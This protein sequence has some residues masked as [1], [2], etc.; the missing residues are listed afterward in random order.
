MKPKLTKALIVKHAI[1][2]ADQHGLEALSMRGL[3]STLDVKA[4]SLYNHIKNK[5]DL[6]ESMIDQ[7]IGYLSYEHQGIW[8]EAV[9]A[10]SR[11]L[12]E[13]LLKHRWGVLPLMYGF[14]TGPFITKD[15]DRSIGILRQAGFSYQA[16]DQI[17]SSV[18]AYIYGF[19]LSRLNFPIEE[20]NYQNI[21]DDYKDFFPKDEL[22]N[23][24]G[25]SNEIRLGHYS[26][27]TNFEL[28]LDF[29]IK[30]IET[31]LKEKGE[32]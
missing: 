24:W 31:I 17:I 19:V 15:Y 12:K 21:A 9:R 14:H 7:V 16:C 8:Q 27:I 30:G 20:N 25:M 22:P 28:G 10:R 32:L 26:G 6:I 3:S 23:L 1:T 29:I 18:N 2:F 11:A 13:L 4:M 5:E